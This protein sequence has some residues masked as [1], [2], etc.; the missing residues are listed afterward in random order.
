MSRSYRNIVFALVG[1][2]SLANAQN[3]AGPPQQTKAQANPTQPAPA[4][5]PPSAKPVEPIQALELNRPCKEGGDARDSD[6]CAQWKAADAA[7]DA[8]DWTRWGVLIGIIGTVGLFWTLYY[9]RAAVKA[10]QSATKDAENALT[11]RS[12]QRRRCRRFGQN[13]P[14]NNDCSISA[15]GPAGN[16]QFG[17]PAWC[18]LG[19]VSRGKKYWPVPSHERPHQNCLA[20]HSYARRRY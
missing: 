12:A 11:I 17:W 19:C 8:A 7:R 18:P 10:A 16:D 1:V 15:L 14:R 20:N 6:L 5:A 9:S 2:L 3:P 4:V 13:I